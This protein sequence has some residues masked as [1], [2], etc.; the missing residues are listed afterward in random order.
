MTPLQ[1]KPDITLQLK[2]KPHA[3]LYRKT[4]VSYK[5]FKRRVAIDRQCQNP[6]F[7]PKIEASEPLPR[8]VKRPK[9]I[10]PRSRG[11]SCS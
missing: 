7:A 8:L 11:D 2:L 5:L 3:I 1:T 6:D 4:L 9:D 10:R